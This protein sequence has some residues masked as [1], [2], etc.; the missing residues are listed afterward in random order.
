MRFELES[1]R[2]LYRHEPL[3]QR[4]WP[5]LMRGIRDYL[6]RFPE[7][8]NGVLLA[9][10]PDAEDLEE[11][12][13]E[14]LTNVLAPHP[15]ERE[16]T[17]AAV[18][19]LLRDRYVDID[20]TGGR[21]YIRN[22]ERAQRSSA[23]I[24]KQKQRSKGRETAPKGTGDPEGHSPGQPGGQKV[25]QRRDRKRDIR[26][27]PSHT[28]PPLPDETRPDETRARARD[29]GDG[30]TICP[31][32]LVEKADEHR[33]PE[34]FAAK[35]GASVEAVRLA[36]NEFAAY[37]TIGGGSG[38]RRRNWMGR[39]RQRLHELGQQGKLGPPATPAAEPKGPPGI[40]PTDGSGSWVDLARQ[41]PEAYGYDSLED[42]EEDLRR[43]NS[44]RPLPR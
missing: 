10:D 22:Y 14:A 32:N 15:Y 9:I 29:D 13:V 5:L 38:K 18:R 19:G 12:V 1:W 40:D 37:W 7:E 17:I 41:C 33:I 27:P 3:E 21:A 39:L 30:E 31:M 43:Q 44:T 4:A 16:D 8:L 34:Q 23:A 26:P 11:R 25:G 28:L 42:L 6:I 20:V 35:T 24:R 2:K 36:I